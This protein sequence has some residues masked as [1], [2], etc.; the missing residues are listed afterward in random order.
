MGGKWGWEPNGGKWTL[1]LKHCT[2]ESNNEW[3]CHL[4]VTKNKEK[5][6]LVW[7]RRASWASLGPLGHLFISGVLSALP[8]RVGLP[9]IL[10]C[11]LVSLEGV[12]FPK[13]TWPSLIA[14]LSQHAGDTHGNLQCFSPH[15]WS[16]WVRVPGLAWFSDSV[17]KARRVAQ[18]LLPPLPGPSAVKLNAQEILWVQL[19]G[20]KAWC[21]KNRKQG[22]ER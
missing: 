14:D 12:A 4:T 22:L 8:H 2:P 16:P 21:Y 18:H 19:Q 6:R 15:C 20:H 1:V 10:G 17:K 3:V 7:T 5:F 9:S 11:L 13:Q